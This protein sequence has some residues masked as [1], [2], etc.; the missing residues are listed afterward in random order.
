ME[1]CKSLMEEAGENEEMLKSNGRGRGDRG[2]GI[3]L[4][5]GDVISNGRGWEEAGEKEAERGGSLP[6]GDVK[7]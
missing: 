4:P 5:W 6:R 3:S 1:R 2:R 7:V